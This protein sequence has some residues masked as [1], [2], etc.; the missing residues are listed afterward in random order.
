M[1]NGSSIPKLQID[2][3]SKCHP[4]VDTLNISH[5]I[6]STSPWSRR[7]TVD[8]SLY[9]ALTCLFFICTLACPFLVPALHWQRKQTPKSQTACVYKYIG[10]VHLFCAINV[11]L[12]G[13]S[14]NSF[15]IRCI[16][17]AVCKFT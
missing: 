7:S 9:N 12:S 15:D 4:L 2:T 6:T 10:I 1:Q 3:I 13:E 17:R 14:L 11:C 5:L 16:V 8:M